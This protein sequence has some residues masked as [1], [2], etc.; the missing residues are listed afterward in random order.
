MNDEA[1]RKHV[2]AQNPDESQKQSGSK[3]T[4]VEALN[5][6]KSAIGAVGKSERN[7]QQGYN[8]RGVDAVVNAAAPLLNKHGIVIMPMLKQVHY[9]TVAVGRNQT[10]MAHARVQVVYRFY[11]PGGDWIDAEVPGESMDSG[12]KAT[13]KAMS[14]AY[15]IAL[16]QALNLP[17]DERDP[18]ED[19]YERSAEPEVVLASREQLVELRTL[20]TGLGHTDRAECLDI[21]EQLVGHK[22]ADNP[23]N[24]TADEIGGINAALKRLNGESEKLD[25]LLGVESG[26]VG[27]E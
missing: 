10:P 2:A 16:L 12:D 14:V 15:R 21:A 8:F 7:A 5:S 22:L 4:V 18:D 23:G 13:P 26:G 17:T 19:S 1:V 6:V 11:G 3:P 9:D 20:L 24:L 27:Y 25:E